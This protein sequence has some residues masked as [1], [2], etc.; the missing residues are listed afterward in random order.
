MRF[1]KHLILFVST[2]LSHERRPSVQ[3][4][5][6]WSGLLDT[7]KP[8]RLSYPMRLFFRVLIFS[9]TTSII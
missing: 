7:D 9:S 5:P 1:R 4:G 6:T 8:A 3:V 2:W